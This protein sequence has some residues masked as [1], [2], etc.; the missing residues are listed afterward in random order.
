[1]KT[2]EDCGCRVYSHGC[3]NCDEMEY[4]SMQEDDIIIQETI[5]E[6]LQQSAVMCFS[7]VGTLNE[8]HAKCERCGKEEWQHK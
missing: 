4:I 2:C 7:F 5:A 8:A 3:V 6:I 1:M